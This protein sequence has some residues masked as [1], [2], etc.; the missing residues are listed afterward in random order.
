VNWRGDDVGVLNRKLIRDLWRLKWQLAAIALLVACGVSVA[1]MAFSTQKAL[2]GAQREYYAGTRF[3]DVFASATRAPLALVDELARIDGVLFVDARAVK[4]GLM[5]VPGLLRP[6]TVRLIAMPNDDRR[7]LNRTVLIAGRLPDPTRVDEAVA[8][9]TFLDAAHIRLGDH[10]S[11]AL[12]GHCLTFTIVG[13]ALSPEYVYVPSFGPMPDDAHSGVLWAPRDAVEKPSGLGGA[14]SAVSLALAPGASQAK[15]IAAVDRLLAPYGGTPAYTRA[16]HISHRFQQE[17]IDRMSVM[18]TVIPPVFLIVAA[19]LVHLV[20]GRLVESERDQVGLLKAFGYSDISA[21]TI[22]LKMAGLVGVSGALAG[23]AIGGWLGQVIIAVLAQYM[24]FPD[25]IGRFSWTAFGVSGALSVAAAIGGSLLAVRRAVRLSPAVA[26]QPPTPTA[27]RKGLL[28]QVGVMRTLDQPT[29]MI[30]RNIE[31]FPLRAASTVA[32]LSVSVSLL[33]GS[34]FLFSAIDAVVDQAYFRARRWTDEVT[35]ADNRDVHAIAEMARQPAV[36]RAEPFRHVSAYL[37]AHARSERVVV[38]GLEEHAELERPLN[39]SGDRVAFKG[40]S[41]VLSQALA[42]RL[43]ARPGEVVELEV[44]EGLRPR[45]LLPVSA[46]DHDYAGLTAHMTRE[47]LNR[48]MGDGDLASGAD[49]VIA[50]DQREAFYRATAS[51]PQIV[52]AGSRDDTVAMFRSAIAAAMTTEM[53]FF[54][55]F[56]GAIAFGIAYNISRIALSDRARDLATLRVLGFSPVECA[57]ILSGE[58]VLLALVATPVGVG[59]GFALA[60][61]LAA[62]FTRQDFY[63]PFVISPGGLGLAFTTYM[64]AVTLAAAMV[65]Q[66]IWRFDLVAVLKTRD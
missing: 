9:K 43:G 66:R 15:A 25:L 23:G 64:A 49:L 27:F 4:V 50:T 26:M 57:Y 14:F 20:L 11:L 53:A 63:L 33:V 21:A 31:R 60:H 39:A 17:R 10:L 34:Q 62:A 52:S 59:G 24:R 28:E 51:M 45:T 29:R 6:A 65:A 3:G 61:A 32:G 22:Y 42:G 37:R 13:S 36:L 46:I 44:T 2:V 54:L 47:A 41:L 16:D 19:A 1:V 48:L 35:F 30:A 55:G 12:N 40:R 58:L 5:E 7:A 56:A 18:A 8:L 38:F